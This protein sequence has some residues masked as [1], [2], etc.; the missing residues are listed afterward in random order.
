MT[1]D[2]SEVQLPADEV[3]DDTVVMQKELE[4]DPDGIEEVEEE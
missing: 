1:L 3:E 2:P 4:E